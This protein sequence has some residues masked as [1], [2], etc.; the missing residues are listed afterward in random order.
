LRRS[1]GYLLHRVVGLKGNP[2][3]ANLF[4]I[5]ACLQ[6]HEWVRLRAVAQFRTGPTGQL[7]FRGR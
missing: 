2:T 1:C 4:K 5:I 6:E 3:A 7:D